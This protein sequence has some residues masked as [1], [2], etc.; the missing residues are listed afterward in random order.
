M[1]VTMPSLVTTRAKYI[2][3]WDRFS[4]PRLSWFLKAL[5]W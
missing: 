4:D 5:H 2:Q 1:G 3:H